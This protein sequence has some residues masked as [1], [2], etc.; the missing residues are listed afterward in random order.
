M[1]P[2]V[3][4]LRFTVY[5][6]AD[7]SI[8]IWYAFRKWNQASG[9][10]VVAVPS[11]F[12]SPREKYGKRANYGS[13]LYDVEVPLETSDS[14][15][16]YGSDTPRKYSGTEGLTP[17]DSSMHPFLTRHCRVIRARTSLQRLKGSL[18][19]IRRFL[20]A[21]R[22]P[23][24]PSELRNQ[25]HASYTQFFF[26]ATIND[27]DYFFV[28]RRIKG[29]TMILVGNSVASKRNNILMI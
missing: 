23:A 28:Q 26:I 2:E 29:P 24:T 11:L 16:T 17:L 13:S 9:W 4:A 12:L 14:S 20:V 6:T 19:S 5:G 1:E 22:F 10:G 8:D 18:V 27:A 21:T 7:A 15:R 25:P 3:R